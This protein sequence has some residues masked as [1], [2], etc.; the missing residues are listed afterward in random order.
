MRVAIVGHFTYFAN[1]FLEGWED[2]TDVLCVDVNEGYYTWL[3]C[4][5]NFRPHITLFFRAELYP[6]RLVESIPGIRVAL[7]SEPIPNFRNG[8]FEHTAETDLRLIVY[9]N[10]S[11]NSFHWRIYYDV[12]KTESAAQLGLPINEFR[13]LPIDTSVFRPPVCNEVSSR[14]YDVCFVGKPTPHRIEKLDFLRSSHFSFIWVAHGVSGSDL[15]SLFRKSKIML[16]VH[17]D[18]KEAMEPRIYLG[19]TCGALV[20]SEVLSS[21][22]SHFC[23]RII[24]VSGAWNDQIVKSLLDVAAMGYEDAIMMSQME[25]L[26]ARR[27]LQDLVARFSLTDK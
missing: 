27:L 23:D 25:A 9:R 16:N 14:E 22:A 19:A 3:L 13:P 6:K 1:H 5:R 17:A 20:V 15:A 24:E 18:A 21:P 7:L 2:D 11:W 10:M 8:E 12:G 26:S 4:V